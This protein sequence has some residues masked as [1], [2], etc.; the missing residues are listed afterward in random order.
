M[1]LF[2]DQAA[3][4]QRQKLQRKQTLMMALGGGA[5]LITGLLTIASSIIGGLTTDLDKDNAEQQLQAKQALFQREAGALALLQREPNN[6][7]ALKVLADVR[8]ELE[9]YAG[10]IE[11]LEQ[12][13]AMFPDDQELQNMRSQVISTTH[14]F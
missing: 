4:K 3:E 6:P 2:S 1:P 14:G 9:D 8:F 12:L 7:N 5:F 13:V 11:P 10:A